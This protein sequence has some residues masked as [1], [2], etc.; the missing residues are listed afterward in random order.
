M[1]FITVFGMWLFVF[2]LSM[3]LTVQGCRKKLS[4]SDMEG[5]IYGLC[6]SL[7]VLT[8]MAIIS[9]FV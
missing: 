6:F 8:V 5:R 1:M 7:V 4:I 9:K 2:L 3:S